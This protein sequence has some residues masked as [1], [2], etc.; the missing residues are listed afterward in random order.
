[1]IEAGSGVVSRDYLAL[2]TPPAVL[3]KTV[4]RRDSGT[5]AYR[6]VFTACLPEDSRR[7]VISKVVNGHHTSFFLQPR[8][9]C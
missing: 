3:R 6:D 4:C 2:F 9:P 1:M 5:R 8:F 7:R